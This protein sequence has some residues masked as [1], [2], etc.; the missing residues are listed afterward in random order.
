MDIERWREDVLRPLLDGE[1]PTA[2]P[3]E[4][5]GL[6]L[7]AADTDRTQDYVFESAKLPEVRGASRQLDDKNEQIADL[8]RGRFHP[9]CVIYAGG[10]SLL[11]LVPHLPADLDELR[12]QIEAKYP[13]ET[14]AA[15]ITADWRPV[16]AEMVCQGYP[17]G[18]FGGL[19]RWADGWLRRRK[20]DKPPGP[21]YEVV[22]HAMRCRSC[23]FRPADPHV[24]LPDWPLCEVCDGKRA[25]EGR[26]AWF[27]RFQQ[28]LE[29]HPELA[30]EHYY[31]NHDPF[32]RFPTPGEEEKSPPRWL[33]Q[34]LSELSRASRAR[35]G[36]V[37]FIYLDGDGLGDLFHAFGTASKYRDFST[38]IEKA[39]KRAVMSALATHLHPAGVQ[40]S[41]ARAQVG[42]GPLPGEW[43]WIHPFEIITIGG[44]DVWLIVPGDMALPVATAIVTGFRDAGLR[45]PDNHKLCTLS[46]GV[47]IADDHN[48]VR[49]LRDLAKELAREAK[50]ARR[51]ADAEIG[52]VDFH[53]F[54]SADMLDRTLAVLRRRYPYTFPDGAKD[55]RL[56][57]RPYPADALAAL[58]EKLQA[59]RART[60][61]FPTSQMHLLAESLLRGRHESSLFY[62][63]QRA[64]DTKGHFDL[65][66]AAL[67]VAQ[68]VD[69]NHPIPW[70]KLDDDR[71]SYQTALWDIA[72]LYDFVSITKER[73]HGHD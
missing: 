24:S 34:D 32:P 69:E 55:L 62:E 60:P 43:V 5:G 51:D 47:V 27:R 67:A 18:G 7:L 20:E 11:A 12:S 52:Y 8:V 14:G 40:A 68:K 38:Q 21:F 65:L 39:M 10:G 41:E 58:W 48:P 4:L 53:I 30:N 17:D 16:T 28:F 59:L 33:P 72:E 57:A 44:D 31:K 42:E 1:E 70:Q 19:A 46:G 45:H 15:T 61:P 2:N 49:V 36:Y 13:T 56:L 35:K 63:Y 23:H 6:A 37:G 71:Y 9:D 64:R 26:N 66:D 22:S 3:D 50:R 54:K 29:K 25:Y 73:S